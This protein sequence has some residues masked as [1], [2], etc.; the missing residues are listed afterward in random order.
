MPK[1]PDLDYWKFRA[2]VN[3]VRAIEV[4]ANRAASE[5]KQ[6]I[7]AADQKAQAFA[8]S[9]GL[10]PAKGYRWD[11]ATCELIEG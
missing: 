11:D 2:L 10:D 3:D 1:I 6:R 7:A 4:D 5:F 8:V 9:I